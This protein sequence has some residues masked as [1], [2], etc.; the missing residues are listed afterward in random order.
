VSSS[1]EQAPAGASPRPE[2]RTR[3]ARQLL[4][5]RRYGLQVGTIGMGLILW[6]ILA[7]GAS[8]TWLH[9]D[10]YSALMSTVPQTGI[11]ALALTLVVIAR[12]IDLSFG[13]VMA[14]ASWVF[15]ATRQPELGLIAGLAA[16]LGAG[17]LNGA[18]VVRFGIPSLVAT[19]GTWFFWAGIVNVGTSGGGA[20]TDF[21]NG[22]VSNL[23][24]GRIGGYVPAEFVWMIGIAVVFWVLLNRHR[25]GAHVYLVGDNEQSARMMGV[26]TNRVRVA[27]FALCGLSAA[28]AGI[29]S[30]LESRYFWPTVG[31]GAM[32][33]TVAAVFL[34]GTSIF[35]GRGTILGTVIGAFVI[36]AIEPGIVS[37]DLTGF[38]TQVIYGAV[39]VMA[40]IMQSLLMRRAER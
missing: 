40:L 13:S 27:V 12:E 31:S 17:L 6:T 33:P 5:F 26:R 39:I 4:S 7:V 10:I 15:I 3:S 23:I 28:L 24:T 25:F 2:V 36:G 11:V 8:G 30:T 20:D 35:G 21:A 19:I 18:I 1:V 9:F 32:L 22:F 38:Y 14:V 16:G 34:G 29:A 37:L